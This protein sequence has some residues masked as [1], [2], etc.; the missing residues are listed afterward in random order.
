M[1]KI[2]KTTA[3]KLYNDGKAITLYPSKVRPG[4]PWISGLD[5][6]K[7]LHGD[8][9]SMIDMFEVYNCNYNETGKRVA[10]YT[11]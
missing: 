5:I 6:E 3:R 1:R 11:A 2:N 10:Y 8:F 7:A 9:D 4:N